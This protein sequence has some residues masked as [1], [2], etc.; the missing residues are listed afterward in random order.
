M[1]NLERWQT[2]KSTCRYGF[3]LEKKKYWYIKIDIQ[4]CNV[5]IVMVHF[6]WYIYKH[7]CIWSIAFWKLTIIRYFSSRQFFCEKMANSG[8]F[9][10]GQLDIKGCLVAPDKWFSKITFLGQVSF[11]REKNTKQVVD[12]S[13]KCHHCRYKLLWQQG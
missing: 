8:K 13:I 11:T 12:V 3:N 10:Q 1:S 5:V 6:Q 7:C 4:P 9:L 2:W